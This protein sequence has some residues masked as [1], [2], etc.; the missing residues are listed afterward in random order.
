M[1]IYF[2]KSFSFDLEKLNLVFAFDKN[3]DAFNLLLEADKTVRSELNL[4]LFYIFFLKILVMVNEILNLQSLYRVKQLK[5][6]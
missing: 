1:Y 2:D 3:K 6:S 5:F 4:F